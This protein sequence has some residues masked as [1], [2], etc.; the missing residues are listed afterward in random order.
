MEPIERFRDQFVANCP[1]EI[2][3]QLLDKNQ[4]IVFSNLP[5]NTQAKLGFD[6]SP[7]Y[8]TLVEEQQTYRSVTCTNPNNGLRVTFSGNFFFGPSQPPREGS[9]PRFDR[10]LLLPATRTM[11]AIEIVFLD[12]AGQTIARVPIQLSLNQMDLRDEKRMFSKAMFRSLPQTSPLSKEATMFNSAMAQGNL[13]K[14]VPADFIKTLANVTKRDFIS[15][16]IAE[17]LRKSTEGRQLIMAVRAEDISLRNPS[18]VSQLIKRKYDW[19]EP[20]NWTVIRPADLWHWKQT[21]PRRSKLEAIATT[22][23]MDPESRLDTRAKV[24][25]L[26]PLVNNTGAFF[27]SWNQAFQS[28]TGPNDNRLALR[29]W[30]QLNP[31]QKRQIQSLAPD[32]VVKFQFGKLSTGVQKEIANVV[33]LGPNSLS[34]SPISRAEIAFRKSEPTELFPDGIDPKQPLTVKKLI[35]KTISYQVSLPNGDR[36]WGLVPPSD[37]AMEL[38]MIKR[39]PSGTEQ[40]MQPTSD[41]LFVGETTTYEFSLG[42]IKWFVSD[43]SLDRSKK[44]KPDS[45]PE[46]Y[47]SEYKKGSERVN[48]FKA[49]NPVGGPIILPGNQFI[50]VPPPTLRD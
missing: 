34:F 32:K 43:L 42:N 20:D 29:V 15:Y 36:S 30:N 24:A 6:L 37:L 13:R 14:S 49:R 10:V 25:G 19:K 8:K 26:V 11:P 27:T 45:L 48:Q 35:Q 23:L 5:T 41:D 33:Y 50:R 28:E 38:F 31:E 7:L 22:L 17:N 18:L 39:M 44:Y 47:A 46:P 1:P 9:E 12:R 3:V 40:S 2:L 21:E 4:R 16:S